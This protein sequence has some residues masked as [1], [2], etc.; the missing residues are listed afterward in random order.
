MQRGRS[1]GRGAVPSA[2]AR[3]STLLGSGSSRGLGPLSFFAAVHHPRRQVNALLLDVRAFLLA[4]STLLLAICALAERRQL[5]AHLLHGP[6]E[7]RE[8]TGNARYVLFRCH[9]P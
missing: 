7:V 1:D 3:Q 8:L 4:V 6:S 2:I 9:G 5:A